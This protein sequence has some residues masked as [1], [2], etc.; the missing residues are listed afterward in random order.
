MSANTQT[1]GNGGVQG[2]KQKIEYFVDL[3][4]GVGNGD[5]DKQKVRAHYFLVSSNGDLI[6]FIVSPKFGDKKAISA[7]AAGT[8]KRVRENWIGHTP[9]DKRS[10]SHVNFLNGNH[11]R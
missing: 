6:F 4:E 11:R 8:W 7:F 1:D 2:L 3:N 9:G 5:G 10:L